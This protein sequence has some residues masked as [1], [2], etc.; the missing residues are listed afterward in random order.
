MRLNRPWRVGP[1]RPQRGGSLIEVL[2]ALLLL[3]LGVMGMLSLQT[4]TLLEAR[5]TQARA[6][7]VHLS[8]DLLERMQT[9]RRLHPA[10]SQWDP[11]SYLVDWGATPLMVDCYRS[12]CPARELA[13]FDMR[14]WKQAL[15]HWLPGGDAR[16]FRSSTD[17]SQF[18]VLIGWRL[19]PQPAPVDAPGPSASVPA[20]PAA[21]CAEGLVC[22]LVYI[23]P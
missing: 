7:A 21:P 22:H 13:H 3:A 14:Q 18:G 12:P 1:R 19:L 15:A 2:V 10:A 6:H 5:A 9:H 23:R 17:P 16:V 20:P 4:R 8:S 11:G